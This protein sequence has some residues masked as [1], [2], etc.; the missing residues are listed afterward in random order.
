MARGDMGSYPKKAAA[1]RNV[2]PGSHCIVER[3]SFRNQ[4]ISAVVCRSKSG[5]LYC[6]I[7]F[8]PDS[9]L[10]R[11][12]EVLPCLNHFTSTSKQPPIGVVHISPRERRCCLRALTPA[13]ADVIFRMEHIPAGASPRSWPFPFRQPM[14]RAEF[15]LARHGCSPT[16]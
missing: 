5:E 9:R 15:L 11:E 16:T 3:L 10:K 12:K 2:P 14:L 6:Y 4:P 7:G 8:Y 13:S 1:C